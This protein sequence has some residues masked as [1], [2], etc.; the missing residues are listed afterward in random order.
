VRQ[1]L[2][3]RIEALLAPIADREG[4]E[5]V[6]VEIAGAASAPVVRIF[7]DRDG[8]VD[9]DAIVEANGWISDTLDES[10]PIETAYTLE[11]SSPGVDRP[12]TKVEHFERFCGENATVKTRPLD[13]RSSFKGAIT[14]VDGDTVLLKTEDEIVRI[15]FSA[16]VKARLKGRVDFSPKGAD[17]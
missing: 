8:G 4:Y 11:V 6:A 15:P 16:I 3:E 13:G 1:S 5:L 17:E 9:I 7:I 12:L 14:A 2:P 10:D